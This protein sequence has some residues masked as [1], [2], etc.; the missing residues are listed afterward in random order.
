MKVRRVKDPA[1]K[2]RV[3]YQYGYSG[4]VFCGKDARERALAYGQRNA[5]INRLH[6]TVKISAD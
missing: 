6:I 3:C 2:G 4:R 1:R 5:T